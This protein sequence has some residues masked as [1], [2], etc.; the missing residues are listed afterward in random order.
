[1]QAMSETVIVSFPLAMGISLLIIYHFIPNTDLYSF[2]VLQLREA[3]SQ[4]E[5]LQTSNQHL[6]KRL[7]KMKSARNAILKS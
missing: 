6:Q 3:Q 4:I 5:E 7:E 2:L 1:M